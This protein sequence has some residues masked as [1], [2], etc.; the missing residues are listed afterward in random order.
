MKQRSSK[1]LRTTSFYYSNDKSI[2]KVLLTFNKVQKTKLENFDFLHL[3]SSLFFLARHN[4]KSIWSLQIL[5]IPNDCLANLLHSSLFWALCKLRV[6]SY[7]LKTVP[8]LLHIL[9]RTLLSFPHNNCVGVARKV[10]PHLDYWARAVKAA[11]SIGRSSCIT[12]SI[13]L[14]KLKAV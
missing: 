5:N 4:S 7:G 12:F 10:W 13:N 3:L 1:S 11:R 9:M 8:K 6:L 2:P 14:V